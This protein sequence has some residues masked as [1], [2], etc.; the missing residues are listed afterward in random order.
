MYIPLIQGEECSLS[1]LY[2]FSGIPYDK[3]CSPVSDCADRGL[4]SSR[5][6]KTWIKVAPN[7]LLDESPISQ[8]FNL[9]RAQIFS[10]CKDCLEKQ[11]ALLLSEIFEQ[12]LES[13]PL[14]RAYFWKRRSKDAPPT[15]VVDPLNK[16]FYL[17][18]K[19]FGKRI[20]LSTHTKEYAGLAVPFDYNKECMRIAWKVSL[21]YHGQDKR[22]IMH[23]TNYYDI[24]FTKRLG[25]NNRYDCYPQLYCAFQYSKS[26]LGDVSVVKAC[27]IEDI[28]LPC[29]VLTF[30]KFSDEDQLKVIYQL[31]CHLSL[32]HKDQRLHGCIRK[33]N[34]IWRRLADGKLDAR[35]NTSDFSSQPASEAIPCPLSRGYY[36]FLRATDPELLGKH[37]AELHILLGS[38][39][40]ALGYCLY[41][42]LCQENPNFG[43]S[44]ESCF[45]GKMNELDARSLHETEIKAICC[46]L[47]LQISTEPS[48]L[49]RS[50]YQMCLELLN[51]D[52]KQRFS[53]PQLREWL[54]SFVEPEGWN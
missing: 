34:I 47:H 21:T 31:V 41:E 8:K 5:I 53:L 46:D 6:H 50:L 11:S 25:L 37:D 12:I 39:S 24:S 49:K 52:A 42:L 44:A 23:L 29:D 27:A 26:V 48:Y 7:Q 15:F 17:L 36:P 16:F 1:D 35:W 30:R 43:K 33:E 40:W 18:I 19:K 28:Y 38:E 4:L 2:S 14:Y 45:C 3:I 51:P 54:A 22:T 13:L 10:G 32:L 9:R 20:D